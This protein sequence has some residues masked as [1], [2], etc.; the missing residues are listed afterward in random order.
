M[1]TTQAFVSGRQVT[2]DNEQFNIKF[3]KTVEQ[4][5]K[6]VSEAFAEIRVIYRRGC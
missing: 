3:T 6:D 4:L 1:P 2:V 5:K